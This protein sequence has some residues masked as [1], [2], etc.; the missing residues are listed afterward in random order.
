LRKEIF[1]LRRTGGSCVEMA[2]LAEVIS[3]I[4]APRAHLSIRRGSVHRD[5]YCGDDAAWQEWSKAVDVIPMTLREQI[6]ET[7]Q[8]VVESIS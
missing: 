1:G 7:S 6:A 2:Q 5:F 4:L 8:W 3:Q